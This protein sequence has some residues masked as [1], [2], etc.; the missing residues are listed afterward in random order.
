MP[1]G[2]HKDTPLGEL[3]K[4]Y[5]LGLFLNYEVEESWNGNPKSPEVIAKDRAFRAALDEAG[6]RYEWKRDTK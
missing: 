6:C 2:K 1:W 3:D 4:K 5:L